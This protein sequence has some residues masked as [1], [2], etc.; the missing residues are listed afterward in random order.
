MSSDL[1]LDKMLLLTNIEADERQGFIESNPV[2]D[3]TTR[4]LRQA[5]KEKKELQGDI[6]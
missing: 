2:E 5:I 4:E 1:S 6:F 3:M